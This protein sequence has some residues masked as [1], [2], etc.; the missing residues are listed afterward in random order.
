MTRP[1][2]PAEIAGAKALADSYG[3]DADNPEAVPEYVWRGYF[4]DARIVLDAAGAA[5]RSIEEMIEASSLGTPEA[6]AMRASVPQELVDSVME[7]VTAA[8]VR[9][10]GAG[11]QQ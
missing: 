4:T 9:G 1:W 2:S 6:K 3:E 10:A 7:R 8:Q 11:E 5:Q